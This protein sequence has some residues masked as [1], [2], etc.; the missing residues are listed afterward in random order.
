MT[1]L[2]GMSDANAMAEIRTE[3][4][5]HISYPT[6]K[7]VYEDHLIEARRLEDPLTR[8]ELQERA[9]RRQ[10][11]VRSLLLYLVDCV[12]FTYKT[13]RHIDLIY[14]DC[15]AD[16]QAIG[17]WSWGGMA[18]AYLYDYL[19]DSVILNNKTMA[20]STTLFIVE[21]MLICTITAHAWIA[22]R[23]MTSGFLLMVIIET[24]THFSLLSL[25][26]DG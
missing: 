1:R 4:A 8:E 12:L 21:A 6:L 25:T 16:L 26:R 15:M 10:W 9:R 24:C 20:G 22:W 5:G 14:L 17:M 19:D 23:W 2:L 3:S 7:R 13:N 11:C 18:L